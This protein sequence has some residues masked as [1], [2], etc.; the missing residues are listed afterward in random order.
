MKFFAE[1]EKEDERENVNVYWI[2]SLSS[3][4]TALSFWSGDAQCNSQ[5]EIGKIIGNTILQ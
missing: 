1:S 4:T 2:G 5:K 3:A